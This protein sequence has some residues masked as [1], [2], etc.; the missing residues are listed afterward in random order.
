M[1]RYFTWKGTFYARDVTTFRKGFDCMHPYVL[2]E[3]GVN[4]ACVGIP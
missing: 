2:R 1:Q 3:T 4:N